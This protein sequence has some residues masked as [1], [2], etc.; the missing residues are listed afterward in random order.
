MT[1]PRVNNNSVAAV[2]EQSSSNP[3]KCD[4]QIQL[5]DLIQQIDGQN[6]D[7]GRCL[8]DAK[9][10]AGKPLAQQKPNTLESHIEILS[11]FLTDD[12]SEIS[13]ESQ[14]TIHFSAPHTLNEWQ[15]PEQQQTKELTNKLGN[16]ILKNNKWKTAYQLGAALVYV[17][18]TLSVFTFPIAV[19]LYNYVF[20]K[21]EMDKQQSIEGPAD[22]KYEVKFTPQERADVTRVKAEIEALEKELQIKYTPLDD[23]EKPL[24]Y[25]TRVLTGYHRLKAGLRQTRIE[26]KAQEEKQLE[27]ISSLENQLRN[28]GIEGNF[29]ANRSTTDQLKFLTEIYD[30]YIQLDKLITTLRIEGK[31]PCVFMNGS[32]VTLKKTIDKN[33]AL[34]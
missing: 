1:L 26:A 20:V 13:E 27:K 5:K 7:C 16:S 17:L 8:A 29:E 11:A 12:D 19:K 21:L 33:N 3:T 22:E 9:T 15:T 2:Y 24:Q 14:H 28:F 25:Y 31:K 4:L 23:T 34:I 30:D 6:L 18:C 10:Y 32:L